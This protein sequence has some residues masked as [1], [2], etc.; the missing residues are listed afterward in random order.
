MLEHSRA[1][2]AIARRLKAKP[3]HSYLRDFVYG[4][5]DGIVTT[6]AVVAGVAGARLSTA[7]VVILGLANLVADGFSMAVG[8][9][10]AT[11]AER[12]LKDKAR[13]MEQK[14]IE[15]VPEGEK[16]EIRQIFSGK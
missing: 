7:I 5:I 15:T 2:E 12:Q 6:F 13:A 14:H 8:N 1:P 10:L 16:E 11:Q 4:A 3:T 9:F